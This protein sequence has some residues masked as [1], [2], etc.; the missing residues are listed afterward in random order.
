MKGGA[1]CGIAGCGRCQ[2]LQPL[3]QFLAAIKDFIG[4]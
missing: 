2:P 3:P 4:L 1:L